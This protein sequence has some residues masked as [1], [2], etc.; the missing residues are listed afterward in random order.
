MSFSPHPG[1]PLAAQL[2]FG[3]FAVRSG[4]MLAVAIFSWHC[5]DTSWGHS[6]GRGAAFASAP[7]GLGSVVTWSPFDH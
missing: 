2:W 3:P 6:G 1:L 4:A 5:S 7:W